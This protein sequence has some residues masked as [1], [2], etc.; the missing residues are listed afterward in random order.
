[1]IEV[2]RGKTKRELENEWCISSFMKA[3]SSREEAEEKCARNRTGDTHVSGVRFAVDSE[4]PD[5]TACVTWRMGEGDSRKEAEEYCGEN[6][7]ENQQMPASD[8][9]LG[10]VNRDPTPL[11]RC[12][13][14]RMDIYGET[15]EQARR[16]CT[17]MFNDPMF[18]HT[19]AEGDAQQMG[20]ALFKWEY[21]HDD[22]WRSSRIR[23]AE[24]KT[25]RRIEVEK[26]I[27]EIQSDSNDPDHYLPDICLKKRAEKIFNI[28]EGE[29]EAKRRKRTGE[30]ELTVGSL[31]GKTTAQIIKEQQGDQRDFG[32]TRKEILEEIR[33]QT[34]QEERLKKLRRGEKV[35]N[36]KDRNP[37]SALKKP[38]KVIAPDVLQ[39][40]RGS[41]KR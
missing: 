41:K 14:C 31:Y 36:A 7:E 37:H 39:Q 17:K 11:E 28:R 25:H 16:T 40:R 21:D 24:E 9:H 26:I 3:G 5:F 19:F 13:G 6:Q 35:S 8:S 29:R 2:N 33:V 38:L 34:D 27:K 20:A 22:R 23:A 32:K 12:M 30:G 10:I 1:M 15:E 4:D 18:K